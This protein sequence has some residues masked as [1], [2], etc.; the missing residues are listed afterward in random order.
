VPTQK[1]LCMY[2]GQRLPKP[3]QALAGRR[4]RNVRGLQH[5]GE[6]SR[7]NIVDMASKLKSSVRCL[8]RR[9]SPT[10]PTPRRKEIVAGFMILTADDYEGAVAS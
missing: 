1:Y 3:K 5:L 9:A 4:C 6:N 8:R 7:A 2:R 10:A